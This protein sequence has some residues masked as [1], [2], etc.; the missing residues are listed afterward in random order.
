MISKF[1]HHAVVRWRQ[2]T[3]IGIRENLTPLDA[4]YV[5]LTNSVSILGII[6]SIAIYPVA[7]VDDNFFKS[8][9]LNIF[10]QM[11]LASA[12][13]FNFRQWFGFT[14][15][16]LS[17]V[18]FLGTAAQVLMIGTAEG[19]HYWLILTIIIPYF[20]YPTNFTF[21][22]LL[23]SFSMVIGFA[24]ISWWW[25][26][27]YFDNPMSVFFSQ[28]LM[29]TGIML[30]GFY[31]R[32]ST[33]EANSKL[34]MEQEKSE[35]LLKNILPQKVIEQLKSTDGMIAERFP[36]ASVLFADI[37]NF[38]A[39][40]KT[41]HPEELVSLLNTIFSAFDEL[42][43]KYQLE[44]I[45]TIGDAYMVAAGIPEEKAHHAQA[46]AQMA[47]E[48][49]SVIGQIKAKQHVDL[50]LRIGISSGPIVAGV[51]GRRKFAYDLWGDV[52]NL[53]SRMESHGIEGEIQISEDTFYKIADEFECEVRG[54]IEIKGKGEMM[55]YL[56]KNKKTA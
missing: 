15:F 2:F 41:M 10:I 31:F 47:L 52:V 12:L 39:M 36:E 21:I 25:V 32:R 1:I 46:I 14:A 20:V 33:E 42:S 18:A 48:M 5:I 9:P 54:E 56:L 29:A 27:D 30:M 43:E 19:I 11:L 17:T 50:G 38:T 16:Y 24:A 49:K 35:R 13:Y 23:H 22:A 37:V 26:I 28:V 4:K 3:R 6:L 44:K 40:S 51:I 53:A 8:L 7:F 34:V 55:T 45:K